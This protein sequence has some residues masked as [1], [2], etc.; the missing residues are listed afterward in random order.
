[1]GNGPRDVQIEYFTHQETGYGMERHHR[2]LAKHRD[3]VSRRYDAI[4]D[5]GGGGGGGCGGGGGDNTVL[6]DGRKQWRLQ[7]L[8]GSSKRN[9]RISQR[10][11]G[12]VLENKMAR[13]NVRQHFART[14]QR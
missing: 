11:M 10:P 2:H 8:E 14:W 12:L 7:G 5:N 6:Q 1:M 3:N 9:M 4:S 13:T